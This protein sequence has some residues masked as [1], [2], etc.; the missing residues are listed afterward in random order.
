MYSFDSRAPQSAWQGIMTSLS[1]RNNVNDRRQLDPAEEIR[2]CSIDTLRPLPRL[3]GAT[4]KTSF[5]LM[6]HDTVLQIRKPGCG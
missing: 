4:C 3:L 2:S 5:A 6:L 1:W